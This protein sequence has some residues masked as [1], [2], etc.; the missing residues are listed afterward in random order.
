[1]V[2][3][4]YD[5]NMKNGVFRNILCTQTVKSS[6]S[7]L[8]TSEITHEKSFTLSKTAQEWS[9]IYEH[10][11]QHIEPYSNKNRSHFY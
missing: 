10:I 11:D 1:M 5:Q 8:L 6:W 9:R 3:L 7:F 4:V 2:K